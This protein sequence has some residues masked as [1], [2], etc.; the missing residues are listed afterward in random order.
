MILDCA[1]FEET[2][3]FLSVQETARLLSLSEYTIYKMIHNHELPAIQFG[4][5]YKIKAEDIIR[6]VN[7]HI[8]R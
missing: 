4:K 6:Y 1:Q 7:Q 8:T 2:K 3:A 5:R